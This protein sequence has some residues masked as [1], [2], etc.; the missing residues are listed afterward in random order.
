M[1][2]NKEGNEATEDDEDQERARDRHDTREKQQGTR[3]RGKARERE[4]ERGK[5]ERKLRISS[6][7][8]QY[9]R[10]FFLMKFLLIA[11][12]VSAFFLFVTSERFRADLDDNSGLLSHFLFIALCFLLISS[13]LFWFFA[14]RC[15]CHASSG[16][17]YLGKFCYQYSLT[18]CFGFFFF[19][20]SSLVVLLSF[21]SL[22]SFAE[23]ERTSAG[24]GK[25]ILNCLLALLLLDISCSSMMTRCAFLSEPG[26]STDVIMS[27]C[28]ISSR[29]SAGSRFMTNE[30]IYHVRPQAQN[31]MKRLDKASPKGVL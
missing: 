4:R 13:L 21:C 18:L 10:L 27:L 2:K 24:L 17:S 31:G 14:S 22:V 20:L 8:L 12:I 16:W 30:M 29:I 25:S 19:C 23:Q 26:K 6:T 1:V 9:T 11:C 15:V 7:C 28:V 5:T 3:E